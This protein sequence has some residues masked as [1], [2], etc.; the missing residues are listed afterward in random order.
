MRVGG[1]AKFWAEPQ[2][3][4]ELKAALERIAQS[5][6]RLQIFGA[7]SNLV[8]H[9]NGFDGVV[10][11]LGAG[12]TNHRIEGEFLVA[13]GALLL[14][15]LT[16]IALDNDLGNLE[17]AC[18]VPGTVGGSVWGNAGAR[19]FNGT[20]MESR[21]CAADL[22]SLVAFGRDGQRHVLQRDEIKFSYRKSSLGDLI[23]TEATFKLKP[24]DEAA[25]KTHREAVKE[26]LRIRRETQPANAASA[27]C[28][29]KNPRECGAGQLV[30]SLGL[31][32]RQIG[33]AQVSEMHAN[34]IINAGG[35]S[36]EDVR[37]LAAEVEQIALQQRG[38]ALER[39]A[40]FLDV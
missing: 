5:G 33:G 6:A 27:G 7:G 19:G 39:E 28:I 3:E 10:L 4:D 23:V 12:F 9:D 21:D 38:I 32:G 15:K 37:A 8:P 18:G 13:G 34:F 30:E 40:R 26:L 1:T 24:L 36:G 14:P 20:E 16:H 11:K 35:A 17:W 31:K 2:N 22:H 29:W 25:T